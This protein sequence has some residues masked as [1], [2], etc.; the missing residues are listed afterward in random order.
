MKKISG[1]T[2]HEEE[3][4]KLWRLTQV[5]MWRLR[6]TQTWNMVETMQERLWRLLSWYRIENPDFLKDIRI[7]LDPNIELTHFYKILSSLWFQVSIDWEWRSTDWEWTSQLHDGKYKIGTIIW[8][9]KKLRDAVI[10]SLNLLSLLST[11]EDAERC[12]YQ[13]RHDILTG[14]PNRFG[15]IDTINKTLDENIPCV[16]MCFDFNRFKAINDTY[17]HAMGDAA[18]R[19]FADVCREICLEY[20][21]TI[22]RTGGDE[23]MGIFSWKSLQEGQQI[24]KAI[25]DR[26]KS[27]FNVSEDLIDLPKNKKTIE[28]IPFTVSVGLTDTIQQSAPTIPKEGTTPLQAHISKLLHRADKA[29]AAAKKMKNNHHIAV[30]EESFDVDNDMSEIKKKFFETLELLIR[31]WQNDTK[32]LEDICID[33]IKKALA[34]LK[35]ENIVLIKEILGEME[36]K[37][38]IQ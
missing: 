32:T 8:W 31:E 2:T 26:L 38:S 11:Q 4:D 37:S 19:L 13:S 25:Q 1:I 22:A 14:L 24:A 29:A 7:Q 35:Q 10:R 30:W 15:F 34:N 36:G 16:A 12:H 21:G 33:I 5:A 27:K 17:W 28:D 20:A 6:K 18:L 23:F 9:D 3:I